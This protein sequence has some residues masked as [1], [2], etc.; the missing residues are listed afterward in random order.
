[1]KNGKQ[2][3]NVSVWFYNGW[4]EMEN[5]SEGIINLARIDIISIIIIISLVIN[6]LSLKML[7]DNNA[8]Y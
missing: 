4:F 7:F 1:M 3:D 8:K 5:L 6:V 2:Y